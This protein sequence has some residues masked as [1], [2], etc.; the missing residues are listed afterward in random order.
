MWADAYELEGRARPCDPL[1]ELI[2]TGARKIV[3]LAVEAELQDVL[4][5]CAARRLEDGRA[6]VVRGWLPSRARDPDRDRPDHRPHA[7]DR[8]QDRRAGGLPPG[9]AAPRLRKSRSLEA[10]VPR[11]WPRGVSTGGTGPALEVLARRRPGD[12]LQAPPSASRPRGCW[13]TRNGAREAPGRRPRA[14]P[15]SAGGPPGA[16][17]TW[18]ESTRSRPSATAPWVPGRTRGDPARDTPAALPDAKGR[19]CARCPAEIGAT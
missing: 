2:R 8:C 3:H 14:G 4:A 19:R 11:P 12:C 15:E 10:A 17:G 13:N 7:Q 1:T 18:H 16:E 9:Q 6:G 5:S